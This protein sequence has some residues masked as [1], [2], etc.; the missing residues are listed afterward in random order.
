MINVYEYGKALFSLAEEEG[1][2]ESVYEELLAVSRVLE[3]SPDYGTLLDC[4]HPS[5]C[6]H[7]HYAEDSLIISLNQK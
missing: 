1:L 6:S 7:H 2:A 5:R 4:D 3:E